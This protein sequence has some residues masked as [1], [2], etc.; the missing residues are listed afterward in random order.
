[1]QQQRDAEERQKYLASHVPELNISG[2]DKCE[3]LLQYVPTLHASV[4]VC[5]SRNRYS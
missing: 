3:Q 4:S 2:L 1:M 5:H